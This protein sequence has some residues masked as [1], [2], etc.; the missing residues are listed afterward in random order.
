M[1]KKLIVMAVTALLLWLMLR[2]Y[3]LIEADMP[4]PF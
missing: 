3:I 4:L 2:R 1:K